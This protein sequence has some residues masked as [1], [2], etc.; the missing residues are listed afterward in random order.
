[1]EGLQSEAY[2]E[3]RDMQRY[4][5]SIERH[6]M[7]SIENSEM[8]DDPDAPCREEGALEIPFPVRAADSLLA[9]LFFFRASE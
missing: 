7:C 3:L 6:Q 9:A 1:M 4:N 5:H 8:V 2:D